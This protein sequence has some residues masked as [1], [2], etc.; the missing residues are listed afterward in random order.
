MTFLRLKCIKI[1]FYLGSAPDPAGG[2]YSFPPDPLAVF[3]GIYF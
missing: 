1:N 2:T 3:K